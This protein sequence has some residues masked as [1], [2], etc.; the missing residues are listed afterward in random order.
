M[1]AIRKIPQQE[2][3]FGAVATG[4]RVWSYGNMRI[5]R[6]K[7]KET[8]EWWVYNSENPQSVSHFTDQEWSDFC[9]GIKAGEFDTL[10]GS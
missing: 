8:H 4:G 5:T 3:R 2:M 6:I 9:K 7:L 1:S 10:V